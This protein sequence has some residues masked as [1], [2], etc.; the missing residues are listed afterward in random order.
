MQLCPANPNSNVSS[1]LSLLATSSRDLMNRPTPQ[2]KKHTAPRRQHNIC[3]ALGLLF[4]SY[5]LSCS[6]LAPIF[7]LSTAP[8]FY[9]RPYAKTSSKSVRIRMRSVTILAIFA[10]LFNG[11]S[12]ASSGQR[13][14][15]LDDRT[16]TTS[17][18]S[19]AT[20]LTDETEGNA[21]NP[22]QPDSGNDDKEAWQKFG[23]A[24]LA[25]LII[26]ALCVFYQ[27]CMC[28][29]RRRQR[30]ALALESARAETVLG[31][32][33]MVPQG[34]YDDEDNELI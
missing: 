8:T 3:S 20:D 4:L 10:Q 33:A 21:T 11:V 9:L 19:D 29:R 30:R 31:D 23:Y 26:V 13:W 5:L 34:D 6:L 27:C 18:L 7:F 25:V 24:I 15:R 2:N 1:G 14:R 17:D 16:D 32:M 22:P 12:G 28:C